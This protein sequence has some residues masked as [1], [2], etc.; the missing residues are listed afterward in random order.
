[1]KTIEQLRQEAA[2][3]ASAK[4]ADLMDRLEPIPPTPA[5]QHN[6]RCLAVKNALHAAFLAGW[7]AGRDGVQ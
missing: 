2:L 3:Y 7:S 6:G 1:M 5:L 4:T